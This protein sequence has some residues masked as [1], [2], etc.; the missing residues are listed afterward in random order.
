MQRN[1]RQSEHSKR[2]PAR[3]GGRA[4][5][6][7]VDIGSKQAAGGIG[8]FVDRLAHRL[9]TLPI[10]NGV[11]F[12]ATLVL[13]AGAIGYGV[14][15]GG[16]VGEIRVAIGDAMDSGAGALG[17]GVESVAITGR[18]ALSET[19]VHRAA[20]ITA[21]TSIPFFDVGAARNGVKALP[22]VADASVRKFY[23][24][25]IEITIVERTPF[26]LWQRSGK[27][28]IIAA[29]GTVVAAADAA[30][31][32]ALPLVVGTG[33]DRRVRDIVGLLEAHPDISAKTRAAVLVAE[34]RWNLRL[35][36]GIDV[37][38]PEV[39]PDG[40]LTTLARLDRERRLLSRDIA[41]VDLRL[42]DRVTIRLSDEA[43]KARDALRQ[44]TMPRKKGAD[45]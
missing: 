22:M 32:P 28:S 12:L 8:M 20:G 18:S 37:R 15:Q 6:R 26:A 38:L 10:P 25:R 24:G 13:F 33:A 21:A 42:V 1:A 19:E 7:R 4:R 9:T 29:D 36:N 27:L 40:A 5:A 17:F 41:A 11:G 43:S 44:R 35:K 34:R 31:P 3:A 39:N 2:V 23:P 16:H 30:A 14:V 45:T